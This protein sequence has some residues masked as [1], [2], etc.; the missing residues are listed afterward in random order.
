[1]HAR[2][3]GIR[4]AR[5]RLTRAPERVK[6]AAVEHLQNDEVIPLAADMRARAG[7]YGAIGRRAASTVTVTARGD[8]A[9]LEAGGASGLGAILFAGSEY[10]GRI[11]KRTYARRNRGG[12]GA[13]PVKRKTTMMF[14]PHLGRRGYWF[15]PA[16][17]ADLRGL[18]GRTSAAID[19]GLDH[20]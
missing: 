6:R 15:W 3:D 10:G 19:R 17:R 9:V 14:L 11:R 1:M 8:G 5:G 13:H 16:M 20:G 2:I 18:I 7:R 12:S 4:E